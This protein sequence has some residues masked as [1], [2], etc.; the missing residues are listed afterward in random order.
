MGILFILAILVFW[1]LVFGRGVQLIITGFTPK[2]TQSDMLDGIADEDGWSAPD[3][4]YNPRRIVS[5]LMILM[6]SLAPVAFFYFVYFQRAD[7]NSNATGAE[8]GCSTILVE[9][10]TYTVSKGKKPTLAELYTHVDLNLYTACHTPDSQP[11]A[12][13]KQYYLCYLTKEDPVTKE[14]VEIA[15]FAYPTAYH[16]KQRSAFYRSTE[17]EYTHEADI[18]ALFPDLEYGDP[19]PFLKEY[20]TLDEMPSAF[21]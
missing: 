10:E 7:V 8:T 18:Q 6:M 5:G 16:K 9:A 1:L 17:L 20:V 12:H 13:Y 3:A 15:V 21:K 4:R 19:V 2:L 14:I 11:K